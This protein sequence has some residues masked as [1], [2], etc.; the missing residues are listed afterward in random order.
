[1]FMVGL[2]FF[3]MWADLLALCVA[4]PC[5]L[6]GVRS[7]QIL[8]DVCAARGCC[9]GD[10]N[11][12]D[13]DVIVDEMAPN[14]GHPRVEFWEEIIHTVITTSDIKL[15]KACAGNFLLLGPSLICSVLGLVVSLSLIRTYQL[16]QTLRTSG[17]ID[18]A[19]YSREREIE[20]MGVVLHQF[21]LLLVDLLAVCIAIPSLF[22]G[23]RSVQ[24][25]TDVY[26]ADNDQKRWRACFYNLWLL[27]PSI[28]CAT[29][30]L[31]VC[32][33]GIRTYPLLKD[34]NNTPHCR[35]ALHSRDE[36]V[37]AM[38]LVGLHFV[39]L[40]VDVLALCLAVPCL[41]SV[42]RTLQLVVDVLPEKEQSEV[43]IPT[44]QTQPEDVAIDILPPF[45][46]V[47]DA[48]IKR[49]RACWFNFLLI[50]PSLISAVLG[51]ICCLSLIRTYPLIADLTHSPFWSKALYSR[52]NELAL[53][54]LIVENFALLFVDLICIVM[55]LVAAM[56]LI[57]SYYIYSDLSDAWR[58]IAMIPSSDRKGRRELQQSIH[59]ICLSNLLLL[60]LDLLVMPATIIVVGTIYRYVKLRRKFKNTMGKQE[61]PTLVLEPRACVECHGRP[62]GC[63]MCNESNG[64]TDVEANGTTNVETA[65]QAQQSPVVRL[66]YSRRGLSAMWTQESLRETPQS[67]TENA[68]WHSGLDFRKVGE[69]VRREILYECVQV[70]IDI[71][72]FVLGIIVLLTIWRSSLL[73]SGFN[74]YSSASSRRLL[75]ATQAFFTLVD[76]VVFIFGF[77]PLLVTLYRLPV[78]FSNLKTAFTKVLESP[79]E[80][81]VNSFRVLFA[82]GR[83]HHQGAG[84][85]HSGDARETGGSERAGGSGNTIVLCLA[86]EK[87]ASKKFILSQAPYLLLCG[88]STWWDSLSG[89]LGGPTAMAMRSFLPLRLRQVDLLAVNEQTDSEENVVAF[90]V[91]YGVGTLKKSTVEKKLDLIAKAGPHDF[92]L[93]LQCQC[94][95]TSSS[96]PA[97]PS[98]R[99]EEHVLCAIQ[100]NCAQLLHSLQT[101]EAVALDNADIRISRTSAPGQDA[102]KFLVLAQFLQIIPDLFHFVLV[103]LT[104]LNPPHFIMLVVCLFEGK[105]N[106]VRRND[107]LLLSSSKRLKFLFDSGLVHVCGMLNEA[108]KHHLSQK[109]NIK[110]VDHNQPA[111]GSGTFKPADIK[112]GFHANLPDG[113]PFE[114]AMHRPPVEPSVAGQGS[115]GAGSESPLTLLQRETSKLSREASAGEGSESTPILLRK[116]ISRIAV[117]K[118]LCPDDGIDQWNPYV[119]KNLSEDLRQY[120][121][122]LQV[123][124]FAKKESTKHV[125]GQQLSAEINCLYYHALSYM[126][127]L[128]PD[129]CHSILGHL[130]NSEVRPSPHMDSGVGLDEGFAT[131]MAV[132]ERASQHHRFPVSLAFEPAAVVFVHGAGF[133]SSDV[134]DGKRQAAAGGEESPSAYHEAV[135]EPGAAPAASGLKWENLGPLRP[136][137]REL[138]CPEL[139]KAIS[140]TIENLA[141]SELTQGISEL[142]QEEWMGFGIHEL[143]IHDFIKVGAFY[144]KPA[145]A[146][147]TKAQGAVPAAKT[148][149]GVAE[150]ISVAIAVEAK[151]LEEAN[152]TF[153]SP[154]PVLS[155]ND[156]SP[157]HFQPVEEAEAAASSAQHESAPAASEA[158]KNFPSDS[159]FEISGEIPTLASRASAMGDSVPTAAAAANKQELLRFPAGIGLPA[160]ILVANITNKAAKD[161]QSQ[162]VMRHA[163]VVEHME[164][165]KKEIAEEKSSL[166][167]FSRDLSETRY[168]VRACFSFAFMDLARLLLSLVMLLMLLM[169]GYRVPTLFR[170]M[171][172]AEG[173]TWRMR[174]LQKQCTEVTRD[175]ILVFESIVVFLTVYRAFEY[176]A[177]LSDIRMRYSEPARHLRRA[178]H[179]YMRYTPE[180]MDAHG[181]THTHLYTQ[182]IG[183]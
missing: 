72:F 25:I 70:L 157:P 164:T 57:R 168:I 30:G 150:E 173:Y 5:L 47:K 163:A 26:T 133:G 97:A 104:M 87:E 16:V 56:S 144:F 6:S 121:I 110:R 124:S 31:T 137:G 120:L 48:D 83:G 169:T 75:A 51:I 178:G 91:P 38:K 67:T 162:A 103:L 69:G 27:I 9:G 93:Q 161:A 107:A 74:Q 177:E 100:I 153:Q 65:A 96:A 20:M 71:P 119:K 183:A 108:S 13:D 68:R 29:M 136:W 77:V 80:I 8:I 21:S 116:Q 49:W 159:D 15:W 151:P 36:E 76:L 155:I 134:E 140:K 128:E 165:L 106:W 92:V 40:L 146:A 160:G 122:D 17:H 90:E 167:I 73:L 7:A 46:A 52:K 98:S 127:A 154:R 132:S 142:T 179:D 101:G 172:R 11:E 129:A 143:C 33:S 28:L 152:P 115:P 86:G 50:V 64:S 55:A 145:A 166:G 62:G 111:K 14:E 85:E 1:M 41:C 102:F 175:Q 118:M 23:V 170:Q 139:A 148:T 66:E 141:I 37:E 42:V 4:I 174:I 123:L 45:S 2:H 109:T 78:L 125:M 81:R 54:K 130:T 39:L 180:C 44:S 79:S 147:E 22:S 12:H 105:D 59:F 84:A 181:R 89:V 113:T 82:Q 10:E 158:P 19:L 18:K 171:Y 114:V 156:I 3:V 63:A 95:S 53:M 58:N 176:V 138:T 126:A 61:I 182:D 43:Q 131:P 24:L 99:V 112:R 149:I 60:I 135:A 35:K 88:E 117:E 32:L 34:L 94:V